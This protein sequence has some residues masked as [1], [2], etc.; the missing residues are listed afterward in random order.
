MIWQKEGLIFSP[1][2]RAAW[3][4]SHAMAPAAVLLNSGLIRVFV[5]ALDKQGIARIAYV[6]LEAQNPGRVAAVSQSPVLDLGRAGT[7]DENGVFPASVIRHDE[8]IYL[9]YTGFQLGHK[10]RYTM[11]GGLAVS[12]DDGETFTRVRQTPIMDRAEE[13]LYF[14]GGP[15]VLWQSGRFR[16][17]YS[18]GSDWAEVGGKQRPT[19]DI[20]YSESEDGI[21]F[22]L[23][24]RLCLNYDRATEHGLG[25]PQIIREGS[26]YRLFY[27]RR[28]TD[29]QYKSGHAYSLDGL[30]WQRQDEMCGLEHAAKGWDSQ[31]VYFPNVLRA[32][33][34]Y[35][36]FYNG[37]NFGETG[38]GYA[39]L[40]S[41]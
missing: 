22:K 40:K 33:D 13:G 39:V 36:L 2:A 6:D 21:N 12:V 35:Y 34:K 7:F 38:F 18:A 27:T 11:F 14:R 3:W 32:V 15:S 8:K 37:N 41:W 5:G 17:Y 26:A 4:Q 10:V 31:M 29:M 25:R 1:T 24:G 19:Y 30:L 20:F 16:V 23:S 28:T 9:Y